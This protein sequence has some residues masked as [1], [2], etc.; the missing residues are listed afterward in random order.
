MPRSLSQPMLFDGPAL[1]ADWP[2]GRLAP[3]AYDLIMADPP[4]PFEL[5]SPLAPGERPPPAYR[6]SP[7][8]HYRTMSLAEIAALPVAE[9][10]APDCVLWLW[11]TAPGIAMQIEIVA[12][13]GFRFSTSGVWVKETSGGKLA[14]GTGYVLR[15]AH[16][17]FLIGIRGSP[18]LARGVRS[19]VMGALRQHSRKPEAAYRAAEALVPGVARLELFS[20]AAR[21]GWDAF[22]DEAGKF[23]ASKEEATQ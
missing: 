10:A 6:K 15:N 11:G 20:R 18:K 23:D 5:W 12:R 17:P 4:W 13:W 8:A 16:E 22:G 3:S 19:V 9:L 14:F 21:P 7:A 2:W 1:R